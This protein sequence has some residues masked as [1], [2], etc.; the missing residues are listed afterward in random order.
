[1]N[2]FNYFVL[3][4]IWCLLHSSSVS[5]AEEELKE[6]IILNSG[7]TVAEKYPHLVTDPYALITAE[8]IDEQVAAFNKET[9]LKTASL[10]S[11]K[12]HLFVDGDRSIY[13][14]D[15]GEIIDRDEQGQR[16]KY[17]S[18]GAYIVELWFTINNQYPTK[19]RY[20]DY[21]NEDASPEFFTET[22]RD[23]YTDLFGVDY[24]R[25]DPKLHAT[26]NKGVY[27]EA[28]FQ[29]GNEL[30]ELLS[31]PGVNRA[32]HYGL[33]NIEKVVLPAV[34]RPEK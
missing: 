12:L 18:G 11:R 22:C 20:R 17:I 32:E 2:K 10:L 21:F 15:S 4:F 33:K 7:E 9:N 26:T 13:K 23:I 25:Y 16:K 24:A 3:I 8:E 5:I 31:L 27:V 30:R 6:I 28:K 19:E 34:R 29:D 14:D 1:M